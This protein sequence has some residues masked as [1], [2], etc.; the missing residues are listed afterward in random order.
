[1][2]KHAQEGLTAIDTILAQW[3][4]R[5]MPPHGCVVVG[6]KSDDFTKVE[7]VLMEYESL[8]L[9]EAV[10]LSAQNG[11]GLHSLYDRLV[12]STHLRLCIC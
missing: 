4:R 10:A 1:M 3:I 8:G 11:F 5:R 7:T 6:N 12:Q 9:G 2:L